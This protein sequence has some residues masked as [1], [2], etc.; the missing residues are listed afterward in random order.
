[1]LRHSRRGGASATLAR[2]MGLMCWRQGG[3]PS[4]LRAGLTGGEVGDEG[5]GT[6]A[7]RAAHGSPSASLLAGGE[8]PAA[9]AL[10]RHPEGADPEAVGSARGRGVVQGDCAVEPARLPR[11]EQFALAGDGDGFRPAAGS[12]FAVE[13]AHSPEEARAALFV[14]HVRAGSAPR[15]E[16]RPAVAERGDDEAAVGCDRQPAERA[17][18]RGGFRR[19]NREVRLVVLRRVGARRSAPRRR[20]GLRPSRRGGRGCAWLCRGCAWRRR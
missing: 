7:R 9:D 6:G 16:A 4:G 11:A 17:R 19:C 14:G 1:M 18:P 13:A 8:R 5:R 20:R 3:A 15:D 12:A 2:A 10:P